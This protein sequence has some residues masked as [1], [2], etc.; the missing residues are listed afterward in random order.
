MFR[1]RPNLP[2]AFLGGGVQ[3]AVIRAVLMDC[4]WGFVHNWHLLQWNAVMLRVALWFFLCMQLI[5]SVSVNA[6]WFEPE[7]YD[8][9]ILDNMK[10]VQNSKA[11]IL[12]SRSC[13]A[14]FPVPCEKLDPA[15]AEYW[16]CESEPKQVGKH[17]P[18]LSAP[19]PPISQSR[20]K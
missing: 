4:G 7:N 2:H 18:K 19:T 15:T 12:I 20:D 1:G 6:G 9:Y 11:A 5:F 16:N 10:G 17:Q 8:D 14:K 3:A 13:R